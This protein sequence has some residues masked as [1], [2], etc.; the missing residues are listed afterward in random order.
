[1]AIRTL[2]VVHISDRR[3]AR[4]SLAHDAQEYARFYSE[5][6]HCRTEVSAPD[7]LIGQYVRGL[8]TSEFQGRGDE[9]YPARPR[10]VI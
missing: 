1:M 4:F 8:P 7:G 6:H 5:V 10:E 2:Y 3:I 9:W